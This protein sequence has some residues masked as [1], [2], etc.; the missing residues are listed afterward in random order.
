MRILQINKYLKIVG[1]AETYMFQLSKALQ[2][3]GHEVKF[4]GM[5][6]PDNLVC[7]F[8]ELEAENIDFSKQSI[9]KKLGSVLNTIYSKSNRKKIGQVLDTYQPDIVHIHNYN[10]QLTPSI[11]PEIKKRGIKIVQTVH[12][13]QMVCPYHRIY[14][15]QRDEVCT[16]CVTGSFAN[17]IKDR[18]FD[19]SLLKSTVGA[20][21]SYF[22]HSF[23]YYEKYIDAYI[24]PSPFLASLLTHRINKKI[25]ILPN[26]TEVDYDSSKA[27]EL[28]EYYLYYG[29]I[30]E[31][32]GII[33]MI[34]VF[35]E[36]DLHLVLIGK[37]DN[38]QKVEGKIKN[39]EN[40][41]FLGPK[42][43]R[44]LFN[45]VKNAKYVVQISKGYENCPMTVIESF[46]L[47]VPVIASN[48]S[49]FKD[50]IQNKITGFLVDFTN[51]NEVIKELEK[52]NTF[53]ISFFQKNINDFYNKNLAKKKHLEKL[54][55]LYNALLN[56][57]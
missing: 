8:P 26:F 50:L 7:D 34:D 54:M 10:F 28:K 43:G 6:D 39:L 38:E 18:C 49:G 15:F 24:A 44:E 36:T 35:K 4:W 2:D 56:K 47:S 40:I 3:L 22:Y 48:H 41:E 27:I 29:R 5:Q 53:D 46:A 1:G 51:K 57:Q 11:L 9:S 31:E 52:I 37:G 30:S 19:G 32:K 25:E 16:K 45:Y 12:D 33:E 21:E 17:C 55:K 23:N 20:L 13:S 14:N 42:Y